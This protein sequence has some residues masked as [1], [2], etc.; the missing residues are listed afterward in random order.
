MFNA[1]KILFITTFLFIISCDERDVVGCVDNTACNYIANAEKDDGSCVYPEENYDCDGN[2]ISES[3]ECDT[4]SGEALDDNGICCQNTNFPDTFKWALTMTATLGSYDNNIFT[5]SLSI[6]DE[7][8]F[9]NFTIGTHYLSTDSLDLL[10]SSEYNDVVQPP[11][12]VENS[13]YL[14]ISHPDW[15]YQFGDNFTQEYKLHNISALSSAQGIGWDGVIESDFY[16][17]QYLK[18]SFQLDSNEN[19]D[20]E[21]QFS[22]NNLA[23]V[24]ESVCDGDLLFSNDIEFV[25]NSC[26]II[27]DTFNYIIPLALLPSITPF[28]I[29]IYN[30]Y[31][32][33]SIGRYGRGGK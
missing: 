18:I 29:N 8:I 31:I 27:S 12:T 5:S 15:E 1:I 20:S 7:E 26:N 13:I 2:C 11:S 25:N 30:T 16:G 14:Y 24:N 3:D 17:E 28:N 32:Y 33:T 23:P 19:I 9:D 4:C 6:S 22:F 10:G 21:V